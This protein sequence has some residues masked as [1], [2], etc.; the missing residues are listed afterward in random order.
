MSSL[1]ELRHPSIGW[2]PLLWKLGKGLQV[3]DR[4]EWGCAFIHSFIHSLTYAFIN[5]APGTAVSD[6]SQNA[7]WLMESMSGENIRLPDANRSP[8]STFCKHLRVWKAHG[9][10]QADRFTHRAILWHQKI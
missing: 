1:V 7:A 5:H 3:W 2:V 9:N 6:G 4:G 10:W 8:H